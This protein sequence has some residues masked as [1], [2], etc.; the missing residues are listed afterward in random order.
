MRE[1]RTH[2]AAGK[3]RGFI[4]PVPLELCEPSAARRLS[5]F[6]SR[7][8]LTQM[9]LIIIKSRSE[10]LFLSPEGGGKDAP[11]RSDSR[12][13]TIS[14]PD[15]TLFRA[16]SRGGGLRNFP[17]EMNRIPCYRLTRHRCS[18]ETTNYGRYVFEY[19]YNCCV[20]IGLNSS[21]T[22]SNVSSICSPV[23]LLTHMR[24]PCYRR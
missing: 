4:Q 16:E 22:Y 11:S 19:S 15:G 1:N 12:S 2:G 13:R 10:L 17:H 24:V 5:A 20:S 9:L 3:R 14:K 6:H 21:L 7:E 8:K 23:S 18:I